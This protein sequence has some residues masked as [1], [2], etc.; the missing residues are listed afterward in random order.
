MERGALSGQRCLPPFFQK[1]TQV[2]EMHTGN[3]ALCLF[4]VKLRF[5]WDESSRKENENQK[6]G[7]RMMKEKGRFYRRMTGIF[8]WMAL[9]SVNVLAIEEK[10]MELEKMTVTS[11]K[12]TVD[13]VLAPVEAYTVDR[14]DMDYQ[15][16]HFMNN[17]G[18][19]IRDIP[20]VHVAQYYPW[21]PPWVHLRGTGHFLQR[22]VYLIDGIPVHAFLSPAINTRDIENVDVVLGPSSALYGASAAGGAVNIITRRGKAGEGAGLRLAY[23]SNNTFRPSASVG[24]DNG[25]FHYRLSYT[26]DYSDG[27]QMKPIDGMVK[28]AGLGKGQYVKTASVEDNAYDYYWLSAKTGWRN[29]RGTSLTLSVNYQNRYLYGG[30]TN[31][32]TNDHGDTVVSSLQF[33]HNLTDWA[34]ISASTGYQFQGIPSQEN[35]GATLNTTTGAVTVDP[36]ITL[37]EEWDRKRIPVEL[38]GDF[39][40]RQN[41]VLTTGV[42]YARETEDTDDYDLSGTQTYRYDLTTDILGVYLQDQHFF[43]DNRLSLLAGMR[44]DRWEYSGIYD[45]GS[46]NPTPA[47]VDKDTMTYRAGLKFRVNETLSLRTNAGTA[48][49]PGNPKWYFQNKNVGTTHRE[50]NPD[51]DP[52]ETWMVDAGADINIDGWGTL[53]RVTGYLGTIENIMAYSYEAH[54]TLPGTTLVK[55][56]N[57]GEAD[58]YGLELYL[59]QPLTDH[60]SFTGSLTLNHS[61]ITKDITNPANEGN[62]LR[63]APDYYGSVGLR[64]KRPHLV[65]GEIL[66]RFSDDRYYDDTN[67]DLPY[68]HM[69][70]Y[71]TLDAKVWRD[72]ELD[73]KWVLQT[74][75]SGVNLF[76]REYATEIVYVNPGRHVEAAM[77]VKYLF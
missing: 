54:P 67:T 57:I 43:M 19:F 63:N 5:F 53:I 64:Y 12:T 73:D 38:Q 3:L 27:Y 7:D 15:P 32:I 29:T 25:T 70:S 69:K 28:L 14:E 34:Q 37:T 8:V 26:G 41:N 33:K 77:G 10:T 59:K 56:R 22:T 72:W 52:E 23:G 4:Y 42:S 76:D 65:N 51:L 74:S 6:K 66:F 18:E 31:A 61:E 9:F 36:T 46:S 48:F 20:G 49:W 68:F 40:I 30:Q 55:T 45:S 13:E 1:R 44:Y 24:D 39:F 11:T 16:S 62:E 35:G 58:I 75:L 2:K 60:L 17:F 50:A 47:D 71:E 21:G